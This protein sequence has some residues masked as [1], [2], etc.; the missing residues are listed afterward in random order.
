MHKH[1]PPIMPPDSREEKGNPI[2]YKFPRSDKLYGAV[3][4]EACQGGVC[5]QS[6][7]AIEPGKLIYVFKGHRPLAE[8]AGT[9]PTGRLARVRSC[10]NLPDVDAFFYHVGVA[11]I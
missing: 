1:T 10:Q 9:A 4:V 8:Q 11:Y 5:F 2:C 7:Y 6:G 3:I